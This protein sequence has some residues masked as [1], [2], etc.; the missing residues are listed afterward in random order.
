MLAM[1]QNSLTIC[2]S[3]AERDQKTPNRWT[4]AVSAHIETGSQTPL[5]AIIDITLDG[6]PLVAKHSQQLTA[7]PLG[8]VKSDFVITIPNNIPITSWYP[9]DVA[10][11][12]QQLYS[13]QV[14]LSFTRQSGSVGSDQTNRFPD[15][16]SDAEPDP[17]RWPHF[18]VNGHRVFAKGSN[19]IPA[20][21][22][23]EDLTEAYVRDLLVSTVSANM[24]MLRVWGGGVYESDV[25]YGNNEIESVIAAFV[26]DERHKQNYRELFVKHMQT[27]VTAGDTSRP[28][29]TSSPS[30]GL[31]DKVEN[32]TAKDP[33]DLRYGDVHSYNYMSPQWDSS[34]YPRDKFIS[35]YGQLSYTS[36]DTWRTALPDSDTTYQTSSSVRHKN[37]LGDSVLPL[38]AQKAFTT[39]QYYTDLDMLSGIV[40]NEGTSLAQ[41]VAPGIQNMT[42]TVEKFAELV[43]ASKALFY[44]LNKTTITEFYVKHVNNSDPQAMRQ[45]YYDYYGDLLIKC[46]TYL[47]AKKYQELSAGKSNAHFYELTYQGKGVGWLCPAG[48]LCHGAEVLAEA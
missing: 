19:W 8:S 34:V 5:D 31:R 15:H 9:N 13:L 38:L 39:H 46:P 20:N 7:D 21:V 22:L 17:R 11:N 33:G 37:R 48:Q 18:E 16:K 29:V 1:A 26:S 12:T 23:Q 25:F 24:N 43:N 14:R 40:Q 45:A 28:F 41:M 27:L 6:K 35:E 42:I 3:K 30:N 4:L 47:F 32:Y 2:L 44:G 10:D 36:L